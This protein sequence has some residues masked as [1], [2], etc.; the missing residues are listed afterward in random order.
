MFLCYSDSSDKHYWENFYL[1]NSL[2]LGISSSIHKLGIYVA[3][4]AIS[5][6]ISCVL[7]NLLWNAHNLVL[8]EKHL[9]NKDFV[10][11]NQIFKLLVSAPKVAKG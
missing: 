4:P 3:D 6:K 1:D 10:S 11:L 5:C 7:Q 9:K 8:S 2:F